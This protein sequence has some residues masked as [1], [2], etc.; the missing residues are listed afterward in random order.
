LKFWRVSFRDKVACMLSITRPRFEVEKSKHLKNIFGDD[1]LSLPRGASGPKNITVG[2]VILIVPR[3]NKV[4]QAVVAD[5]ANASTATERV[6]GSAIRF[7][8]RYTEKLEVY[9]GD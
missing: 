9:F 3:R 5:I 2:C 7:N 6:I 8:V 1:F 4:S